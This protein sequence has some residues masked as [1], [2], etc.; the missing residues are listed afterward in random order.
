MNQQTS[1]DEK[2]LQGIYYA[3]TAFT[4]WGLVPIYF[5][6]VDHVS[7]WEIL[8]HRV[9]WAVILL[10]CILAYTGQLKELRVPPAY[11]PKL[12]VTAALLSV[13]WLV[14]IYAVVNGNIAETSL[15]YFINPL[16][17]VF[18]GLVFLKEKLRPLQWIAIIIAAAG[19][20]IQL[21]FFG[22]VPWFALALAFSFGFYGLLRKN[23]N[24]HPIG[25]LAIETIIVLPFAVAFLIWTAGIGM[26]SFGDSIRVDLLLALGGFVTSFPLLCFNAAVTRLS[27]TAIGM[28]QYIAPSMSLI[29]AVAYYGEPFELKRML[30]FACIWIALAIFTSEAVMHHRRI[31]APLRTG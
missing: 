19:I 14:F 17:S 1:I 27:L 24:M 31:T 11:L 13:N 4:F 7:P 28:F 23:L 20:G 9:V 3:L 21:V 5:K 15:G 8:A 22:D 30:T 29:L 10:L 25:G 12:F 18:L 26:L 2:V 16:V 6:W